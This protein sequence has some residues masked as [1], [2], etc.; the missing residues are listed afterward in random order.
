MNKNKMFDW[1]NLFSFFGIFLGI[2]LLIFIV[3][4]FVSRPTYKEGFRN[5]TELKK[6][7]ATIGE[8]ID[9]DD[10]DLYIPKYEK[11]YAKKF[12]KSCMQK[13]FENLKWISSCFG[14]TKGAIFSLSFFESILLDVT[15]YRKKQGWNDNFIQKITLTPISKV[16]VF[17]AVQGAYHSLTRDLAQLKKLEIIDENLKIMNPDYYIV[18]LGNFV[19]RSPYSLEIFS[20]ILKLLQINPYNVIALKGKNEAFSSHGQSLYRE[21]EFGMLSGL[22]SSVKEMVE[23]FFQTL[24]LDVYCMMPVE[25]GKKC[26]D[27]F[28]LAPSLIEDVEMFKDM[29][30]DNQARIFSFLNQKQEEK[31]EKCSLLKRE[32]TMQLEH[33]KEINVFCNAVIR[34]I[35]KKHEYE[36]MDGLRLIGWLNKTIIWT[37]LSTSAES[38]RKFLNFFYD[39]FVV[40]SPAEKMQDWIITL[41]NRDIR[42]K[43][44]SFNQRAYYFF[45]GKELKK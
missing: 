29:K 23:M 9:S 28:E 25:R 4:L 36:K 7:G 32:E 17:G 39:A 1:M 35:D 44:E 2:G 26:M 21:I 3:F 19:N 13:F 41:Y 24:P 31:V 45:T 20:M 37:I 27:M 15:M 42:G 14:L 33:G 6:Y 22:S 11:Y 40:I 30:D 43:S 8:F 38:Y 34:D 16:V 10:E 5:L 12:S 18:F